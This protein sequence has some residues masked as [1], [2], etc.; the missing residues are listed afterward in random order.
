MDKLKEAVYNSDQPVAKMET[1]TLVKFISEE[2]NK[3]IL[4]GI[5]PVEPFREGARGTYGGDFLAQGL[6]ACWETVRPELQ[7]HS[8]H[9]Y[10]VKAGSNKSNLRW[11]IMKISD[12]RNFSNRLA[13]AY[14]IHSNQ[15]L[16]TIQASFIKNNNQDSKYNEY[17]ELVRLNKE[18]KT[19]PFEFSKL[20]N[21][22]F[23]KLKDKLEDLSYIVHTNENIA[24]IL[25][26]DLFSENKNLNLDDVGNTELG[27]FA[28]ML[29]NY[30]LGKDFVRQSHLGLAFISDSIWLACVIKAIGLPFG[31]DEKD[32][33][34]V[35]LDHSL[36]FHDLKFDSS[37]WM[38]LDFRFL[39]MGNNRILAVINFYTLEGK[40]VATATQEAYGFL[41]KAMVDKSRKLHENAQMKIESNSVAAKL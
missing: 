22:R 28:K 35:S 10:F 4:E 19:F 18:I 41:P 27:L 7:P 20:P 40:L 25:P 6:N 34:R 14:Q 38:F 8:L 37:D 12:S 21:K 3:V 31:V 15:L 16:F 33:F 36:Y 30:T 9:S 1:K 26:S 39:K 2:G 11:E 17:N 29:D 32:F 24:H 23:N 5:Y 13:M